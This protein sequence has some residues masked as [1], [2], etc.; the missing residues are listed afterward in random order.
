MSRKLQVKKKAI[1]DNF[2]KYNPNF[3][4][5]NFKYPQYSFKQSND[6]KPKISNNLGPGSYNINKNFLGWSY[7]MG[8]DRR[9][10]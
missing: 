6:V 3:Q 8:K 1:Q 5:I 9:F 4:P 2:Y 10:K 7:S